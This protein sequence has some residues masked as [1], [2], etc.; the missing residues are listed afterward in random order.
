M[1]KSVYLDY[2]AATPVDSRVLAAM[3][4][5]FSKQF[6]NPSA[7][8]TSSRKIKKNL[9][10]ARDLMARELAVR[11]AE[12]IFTAGGTEANNLAL[13]GIMEQFSGKKL[14]ISAIEHESV[15]EPAKLYNTQEVKVDANGLLDMNDLIKKLDD[16]TVLVSIIYASNEVGTIQDLK[17]VTEIINDAILDRNKR[18]IKTPLYFHTDATQ[19]VSFLNI[20]PKFLGVDLM[21]INGGKIYGPKQSGALFVRS[22]ISLQPIIYGGGQEKNLRSGTENVPAFMGFTEALKISRKLAKSESERLKKLQKELRMKLEKLNP[23]IIFHGHAEKRLPNH[24]SFAVVGYDN[25]RLMMELDELG[26]MVATG[27]AC[28][29]SKA[30]VSHVLA[31]MGVKTEI[32]G[33]TL[34]VTLGRET[35]SSDIKSFVEALASCLNRK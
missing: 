3:Q 14:L 8:Y 26:F 35:T 9:N 2:A 5:Y 18:E 15:R 27:S 22:G 23:E 28:S 29:A 31:A 24:L 16:D 25:E 4:P 30:E 32:A 6:F 13:R 19:A 7:L 10:D 12:I 17:N 34:R 20:S 21:T 33:S 11:G 1:K